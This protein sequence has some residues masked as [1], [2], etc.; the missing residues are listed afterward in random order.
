MG[1]HA[2]G[3]YNKNLKNFNSIRRNLAHPSQAATSKERNPKK[4]GEFNVKPSLHDRF[5]TKFY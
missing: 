3:K 2:N 5:N 1:L 4:D